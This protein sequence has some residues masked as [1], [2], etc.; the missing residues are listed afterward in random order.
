[1]RSQSTLQRLQ[2]VK[3]KKT[4]D[5][6]VS[7]SQKME[8]NVKLI[9]NKSAYLFIWFMQQKKTIFSIQGVLKLSYSE[10]GA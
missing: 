6:F 9:Q 8:F 1:V 7:L 4:P 10:F 3:F 2:E 5:T